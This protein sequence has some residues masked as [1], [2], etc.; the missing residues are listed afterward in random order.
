MVD[1]LALSEKNAKH[2][3]PEKHP[4]LMIFIKGHNWHPLPLPNCKVCH[5]EGGKYGCGCL[6]LKYHK[7]DAVLQLIFDDVVEPGL[8]SFTHE[9]AEL[10]RKI[11]E[12]QN[13][14]KIYIVCSQGVSRS[15]AIAQ[16]LDR[17]LNHRSSDYISPWTLGNPYVRQILALEFCKS[18]PHGDKKW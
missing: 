17:S 10:I 11:T 3:I 2:L 13:W 6:Y 5:G 14:E 15:P 4:S 9:H 7:F 16:V 1:I 12:L 18:P 8:T